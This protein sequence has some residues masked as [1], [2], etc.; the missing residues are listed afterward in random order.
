MPRVNAVSSSNSSRRES[1]GS[2][3]LAL[4]PGDGSHSKRRKRDFRP[5]RFSFFN[6]AC[7]S[8]AVTFIMYAFLLLSMSSRTQLVAPD[9]DVAIPEQLLVNGEPSILETYSVN[10]FQR[11]GT[12]RRP[13]QR[14]SEAAGG[15]LVMKQ[16]SRS[17]QR[18]SSFAIAGGDNQWLSVVGDSSLGGAPSNR[19]VG[20]TEPIFDISELGPAFSPSLAHHIRD[21]SY[22]P[23]CSGL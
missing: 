3:M 1:T 22:R 21:I 13:P 20:I 5:R 12:S 10:D 11:A 18:Q 23:Q 7:V 8:V 2:A 6:L 17:G 9:V 4:S 15:D 16:K 14:P 19:K